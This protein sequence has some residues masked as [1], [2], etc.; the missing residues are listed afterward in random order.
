MA[1]ELILPFFPET[2]QA[3]IL[4]DA[5]TDLCINGSSAVFVERGGIL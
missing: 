3:L 1:F 5:V 2:I 4:N